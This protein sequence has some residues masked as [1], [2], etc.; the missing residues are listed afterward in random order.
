MRGK[1][2]RARSGRLPQATG[3]GSY[4][5][6]YSPATG[7]REIELREAAIVRQVFERFCSGENCH[8]IACSL[9]EAGTPAFGGGP[10]YPVTIRRML[11]NETY[12][13]RTIF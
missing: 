9:N 5:Y 10:W 3:R 8:G 6:R 12:T 13:G 2:E 1:A 11:L 4:G 7:R